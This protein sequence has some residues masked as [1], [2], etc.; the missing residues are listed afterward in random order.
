[1]ERTGRV[2][3]IVCM[4]VFACLPAAWAGNGANLATLERG[5]TYAKAQLAKI[6]RDKLSTLAFAATME[7]GG[8]ILT[9]IVAGLHEPESLP[10]FERERPTEPWTVVIKSGKATAEFVIEGYGTD[11]TK[12]QLSATV[13]ITMPAQAAYTGKATPPT[14]GQ[15]TPAVAGQASATGSASIDPPLTVA[16]ADGNLDDLKA[17]LAKGANV[18][19]LEDDRRPNTRRHGADAGGGQGERGDRQAAAGKRRGPR[20]ARRQGQHGPA[21]CRLQRTCGGGRRRRACRRS[22]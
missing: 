16:A 12:P 5:V 1:M 15:A 2:A 14:A 7:Q 3:A 11:L 10:R 21:L 13:Q 18:N 20:R 17:L 4:V 22:S 8:D 19:A 9:Y 6:G